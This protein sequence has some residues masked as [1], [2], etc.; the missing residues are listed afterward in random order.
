[1]TEHRPKVGDLIKTMYEVGVVV[2]VPWYTRGDLMIETTKF[3]GRGSSVDSRM[4]RSGE[5]DEVY[6][7]TLLSIGAKEKDG[8]TFW[9]ASVRN[10]KLLEAAPQTVRNIVSDALL[11][12]GEPQYGYYNGTEAT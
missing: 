9:T 7:S 5:M 12:D 8:R 6:L 11:N 3:S 10:A 4:E 2:M 1:M